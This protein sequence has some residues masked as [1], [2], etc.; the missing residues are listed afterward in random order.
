MPKTLQIL[1]ANLYP[2]EGYGYLYTFLCQNR[3]GDK[4][5]RMSQIFKEH[6]VNLNP[7]AL[8]DHF[9]GMTNKRISPIIN[10][11]RSEELDE[12]WGAD[13]AIA[14][15][16]TRREEQR[17]AKELAEQK[18]KERG[19]PASPEF[20]TNLIEEWEKRQG[21]SQNW[22]KEA[23]SFVKNVVTSEKK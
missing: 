4:F 1:E 22:Y 10:L 2:V 12:G 15:A 11:N 18:E 19:E 21:G 20:V 7:D 16:D 14:Y 23:K 3:R 9:D 13:Q 17:K 6:P 8:Y 5:L